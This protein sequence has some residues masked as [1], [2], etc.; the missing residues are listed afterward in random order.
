MKTLEPALRAIAHGYKMS[1]AVCGRALAAIKA[2]GPR[3]YTSP[4]GATL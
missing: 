2:H 4:S 1:Q 3:E